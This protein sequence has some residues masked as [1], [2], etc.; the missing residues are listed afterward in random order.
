MTDVANGTQL[1]NR[2]SLGHIALHYPKPEDGPVAARLLSLLG[3]VETQDLVLP[4]GT[5]FYR[6]VANSDHVRR[7]DGIL[8]LS[9]VPDAQRALLEAVRSALKVGT[10]EQHPAV[11]AMRN[12]LLQDPEASFHVGLLAESLEALEAL[13]LELR[14][15]TECDPDLKGRLK[16]TIN[17]PVPGN[18]EVDARLDASPAFRDVTRHAYGRNGLQVFVETDLLVSGT[19]GESTVIEIDYVFPG[20]DSHILSIVEMG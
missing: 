13:V 4:N 18:S 6:F 11:D 5:H 20:Y 2:Y 10:D 8:Y 7:G 19:L 12:A 9:C 14:K 3:L 17:R 1:R 16:I 15:R